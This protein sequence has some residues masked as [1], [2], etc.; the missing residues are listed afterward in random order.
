MAL[1]EVKTKPNEA[2]VLDFINKVENEQKR[3][4][5]LVILDY[6]KQL[7]QEEPMMWGNSIIGFGYQVVKSPSGREVEWFKVGFSPRKANLTLYV[8]GSLF[9]EE[10]R[11]K[12]LG[13]HKTGGGCLYINKLSDVNMDVLKSIIK[14]TYK[15]FQ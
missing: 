5:S 10:E 1:A 4:D 13:K 3:S 8:N 9:K 11:M 14:D 2:S 6:M 12:A 7:T 15:K